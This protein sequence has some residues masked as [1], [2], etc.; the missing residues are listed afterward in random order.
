MV[1]H[2]YQVV[3]IPWKSHDGIYVCS[4]GL[5]M[6]GGNGMDFILECILSGARGFLLLRPIVLDA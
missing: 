6:S 3:L 4:L 5:A 2:F 1:N